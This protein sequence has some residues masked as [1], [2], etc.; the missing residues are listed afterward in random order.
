MVYHIC[1]LGAS[2]EAD[3][4]NHLISLHPF[5]ISL[6]SVQPPSLCQLLSLVPPRLHPSRVNTSPSANKSKTL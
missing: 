6:S 2:C 3:H 4:Q 5:P 1:C